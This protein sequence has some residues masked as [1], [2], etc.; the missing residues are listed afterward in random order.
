MI[1]IIALGMFVCGL[2][3]G[4]GAYAWASGEKDDAIKLI[5][6]GFASAIVTLIGVLVLQ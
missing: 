4:S 1:T 5:I 2:G 6:C 3:L